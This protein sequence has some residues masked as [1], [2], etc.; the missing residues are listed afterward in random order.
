MLSAQTSDSRQQDSIKISVQ[1]AAWLADKLNELEM[2]KQVLTETQNACDSLIES[3]HALVLNKSDQVE[4]QGKVLD[5]KQE[6]LSYC[7]S[8]VQ[9][10]I[11]ELEVTDKANKQLQSAIK[12]QGNRAK[13]GKVVAGLGGLGLGVLIGVVIGGI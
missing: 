12:K 6:Q 7:N 5:E 4:L 9:S 1:N 11:N 10:L 8:T 3:M 13:W 2:C